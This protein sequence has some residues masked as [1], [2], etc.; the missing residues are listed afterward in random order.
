MIMFDFVI[1][2]PLESAHQS[3]VAPGLNALAAAQ[4]LQVLKLCLWLAAQAGPARPDIWRWR[5]A[6]D[7]L[8]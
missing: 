8:Q 1:V 2:F 6:R 3:D 5:L 7:G 4:R